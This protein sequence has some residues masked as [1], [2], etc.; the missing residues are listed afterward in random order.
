MDSEVRLAGGDHVPI[1]GAVRCPPVKQDARI[2]VV[3]GAASGIGR[4]VVECLLDQDWAV[5]AIDRDE[6]GLQ[7]LA[8]AVSG[9]L[10]VRPADVSKSADLDAAFDDALNMGGSIRA[11]VAAAGIWTPVAV[12]DL[13]DEQWERAIAV[14]LTGTFH[15]ARAGVDHLLRSGGGSFVAIASD[16]GLQGSQNCSAYVVAKHGM[17]GLVRSMALDYGGRG[18]RSNAICPGFVDTSMTEQIFRSAP[19]ELLEARRREVPAGRLASPAEIAD[20]VG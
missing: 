2:A 19:R 3:T 18:I 8:G 13:T 6:T 17:V 14:N 7:T 12:A 9:A 20:V 16:V 1:P 5:A 15:T 10:I 4:A 11:V